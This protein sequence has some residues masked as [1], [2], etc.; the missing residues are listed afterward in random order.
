MNPNWIPNDSKKLQKKYNLIHL[1]SFNPSYF[2]PSSPLYVKSLTRSWRLKKKNSGK[3][4]K[5]CI[6]TLHSYEGQC[7]EVDRLYPALEVRRYLS[8]SLARAAAAAAQIPMSLPM[9]LPMSIVDPPHGMAFRPR[10]STVH[11]HGI[12]TPPVSLDGSEGINRPHGSNH[13]LLDNLE[14]IF[15]LSGSS[16]SSS[17]TTPGSRLESRLE[18]G[19]IPSNSETNEFNLVHSE[20]EF[21]EESLYSDALSRKASLVRILA[22]MSVLVIKKYTHTKC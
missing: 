14:D 12:W 2:F 16:S 5:F 6:Y 7:H 13:D 15:T 19:T 20:N 1:T 11:S 22:C 8:A 10:S 18:I 4:A 3:F 21:D 17:S 9:S